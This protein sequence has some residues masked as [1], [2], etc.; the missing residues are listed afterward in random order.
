MLLLFWCVL[1][2]LPS[3]PLKRP[4]PGVLLRLHGEESWHSNAWTFH[5]NY[6][7]ADTLM[8]F[9]IAM[10][11]APLSSHI[12]SV[13]HGQ[14]WKDAQMLLSTPVLLS[15]GKV[16]VLNWEHGEN[17]QVWWSGQN[18][19]NQSCGL[20]RLQEKGPLSICSTPI[21]LNLFYFITLS[22]AAVSL[23]R[24]LICLLLS[25]FLTPGPFLRF[26]M[27]NLGELAQ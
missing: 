19:S 23:P 5:F 17:K 2:L 26:R 22:Q 18:F 4:H 25:V 11:T 12:I 14:I 1:A 13:P 10:A 21:R 6:S 20:L 9:I 7:G 27:H 24:P 8:T 3:H 15:P 16:K